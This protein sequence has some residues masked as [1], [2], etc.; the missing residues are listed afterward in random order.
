MS[1]TTF[2]AI[3][4]EKINKGLGRAERAGITTVA[5]AQKVADKYRLAWREADHPR[6]GK[7][8]RLYCWSDSILFALK[9]TKRGLFSK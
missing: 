1:Y 7:A 8:W 2:N 6:E 5:D 4:N 9:E 3:R